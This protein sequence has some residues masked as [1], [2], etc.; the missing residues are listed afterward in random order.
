MSTRLKIVLSGQDVIA[1]L[2]LFLSLNRH[3]R[4]AP[5]R[6]GPYQEPFGLSTIRWRAQQYPDP[7]TAGQAQLKA[8]LGHVGRSL[9]LAG[10]GQCL[11]LGQPETSEDP[12]PSPGR[13]GAPGYQQAS[14]LG[15]PGY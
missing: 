10:I 7:P 2:G 11:F 15:R 9:K 8:V 3:T 12:S 13:L 1:G 4:A 5:G 14:L 6:L